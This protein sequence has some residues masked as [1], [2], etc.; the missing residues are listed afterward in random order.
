MGKRKVY[1]SED[2]STSRKTKVIV[3]KS[4][5]MKEKIK[6][7]EGY[8]S[9][10]IYSSI[11]DRTPDKEKTRSEGSISKS[12][13]TSRGSMSS[14]REKG[15]LKSHYK[16]GS[17]VTKSGKFKQ[18]IQE[19]SG[20]KTIL[21]GKEL[22]S[23]GVDILSQKT[24]GR[25]DKWAREQGYTDTGT[26]YSHLDQVPGMKIKNKRKDLKRMEN[27]IGA[28]N[29]TM[30]Q[31]DASKY[32]K[33]ITKRSG[34]VKQK[35]ISQKKYEKK[36]EKSYDHLDKALENVGTGKSTKVKTLTTTRYPSKTVKEDVVKKLGDKGR[37]K[38]FVKSSIVKPKPPRQKD[39]KVYPR[40]SY[41]TTYTPVKK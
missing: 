6:G 9:K 29:S 13:Y 40:H 32:Y 19:V 30:K 3:T 11:D 1:K 39:N 24:R 22:E 16:S 31:P 37:K 27:A 26:D 33:E 4:G 38:T 25:R 8:K 18:V 15:K 12:K 14:K 36:E 5:K 41:H 10:K 17:K 28:A 35:P 7:P 20:Q 21:K 23:G 2:P 34:E